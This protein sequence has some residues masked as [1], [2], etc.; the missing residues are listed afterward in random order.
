MAPSRRFFLLTGVPTLLFGQSRNVRV[1]VTDETGARIAGAEV[2]FIS[3]ED[4]RIDTLRTDARG[5]VSHAGTAYSKLQVK[6][7]GMKSYVRVGPGNTGTL[8]IALSVSRGIVDWSGPAPAVGRVRMRVTDGNGKSLATAHGWAPMGD[9]RTFEAAATGEILFTGLTLGQ[10]TL[11]VAADGFPSKVVTAML[12]SADEV[13][14][15]VSL[16][17]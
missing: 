10:T 14:L 3:P 17:D 5:E 7:P 13:S 11:V 9:Q 4:R 6:S 15:S 8:D 1:R 16:I 12:R 2:T